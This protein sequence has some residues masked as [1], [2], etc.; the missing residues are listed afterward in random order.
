MYNKIF[1]FDEKIKN[2]FNANLIAGVDEAGRG[3]IS[4]PLVSAAVVF[5]K[6]SYISCLKESKSVSP[7]Q[8]RLL[9]QK[10]LSVAEDISCSIISADEINKLG[11]A[12]AN[13]LSMK[14]AVDKLK[15]KPDLVIVDGFHN[16][17]ITDVKQYS[18]VKADKKS[19]VVAA[20]SII[21]KV[22]RDCIMKI[23]HEI[24]PIY[25]FYNNKGYPT[26]KHISAISQIGI[27]ELHRFYAYKF[28]K[29]D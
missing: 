7:Q 18:L 21:A 11:L 26:K 2:K 6:N 13:Y 8:R 15:I 25:D 23:Y 3:S 1:L 10:I 5:N 20:A 12:K 9:F 19:A 29:Q 24:C 28:I 22:L 17:Y 27:S 4:G 16:P 14:I